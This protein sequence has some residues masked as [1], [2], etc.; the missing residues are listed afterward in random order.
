MREILFRGKHISD[1]KWIY[2]VP[3]PNSFTTCIFKLMD[4][5]GELRGFEVYPLT[6]GQFTGLTD[7]NGMTIFEGDIVKNIDGVYIVKYCES[8]TRFALVHNGMISGRPISS[9]TVIGNIYDNP[10]L[11]EE[12]K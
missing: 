3:V 9:G 11:L 8:L 2:G 12:G 1:G 7:K 4:D 10:E 5:I 6:I